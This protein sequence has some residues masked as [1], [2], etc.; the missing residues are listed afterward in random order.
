MKNKIQKIGSVVWEK[1]WLVAAAL[2]LLGMGGFFYYNQVAGA[3]KEIVTISP[4]RQNLRQTIEISGSVDADELANLSFAAAS[5]LSWVGVKEGDEVKKWQAIA[6]VDTRTLQKQLQQDL[7]DFGKERRDHDKTLKDNSFYERKD[8][9]QELRWLFEKAQFDLDN[10]VLDVEIRDIAIR[11]STIVSPIGGIVTQVDKPFAGMTVGPTDL[12]Q[13]VNPTSVYF[14]GVV[15]EVDIAAVRPDQS[16]SL[17][18]DAY[19]NETL[20]TSVG[21]VEFIPSTTR[22][23]GTGYRVRLPLPPN[24]LLK[25]RLGMNG[26]A[27]LLI[28]ERSN[29][30]T[31]PTDSIIVRDEVSYV[32]VK[33]GDKVEERKVETGLSTDD[34]TEIISGLSEADLV[35]VPQQD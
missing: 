28:E 25:Y 1:K 26:T 20:A 8:M 22:S 4:S 33:V 29:V 35:V 23:G 21:K 2:V 3:K 9:D 24:Q 15:D 19:P 11:L 13:I 30:L 34:Y 14:S 32:E 6:S 7:N 31:I 17:T 16:A 12:F 5:R 27:T 18:L 10:T